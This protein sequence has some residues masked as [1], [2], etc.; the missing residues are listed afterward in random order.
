MTTM[1]THEAEARFGELLKQAED[2]E[3]VEIT[4]DGKTVARLVGAPVHDPEVAER[5]AREWIA[6][7]NER[8]I[9]LGDDVTIRQL[10]EEGRM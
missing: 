10:I 5:A 6:Y 3:T 7:R 4:R 8:Q 1:T 2:G 9:T